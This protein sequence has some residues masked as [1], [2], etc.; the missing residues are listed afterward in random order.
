MRLFFYM[1]LLVFVF[2]FVFL[3]HND[4]YAVFTAVFSYN[5]PHSFHTLAVFCAGADDINPRCVYTAVTENIGKFCDVFLNAV[6]YAGEK[7]SQIV[8][9]HLVWINICFFAKRFHISP[10]VCAADRIACACYKNTS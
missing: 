8:W 3:Q 9:E 2:W 7:V 10:Y 4:D 6:K 5:Q 1:Q